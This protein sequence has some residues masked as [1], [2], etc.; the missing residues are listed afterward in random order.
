MRTTTIQ[1]RINPQVKEEAQKVFK[2]LNISMSEAINLY[3]TQVAL[4]RGIPFDIKIPNRITA[5][6]IDQA[7][8]G[9]DTHSVDSPEA[10]FE[11]LED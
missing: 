2:Q 10:L 4:N 8:N 7:E 1:A 6:T 3:F 11:E 5:R 9:I